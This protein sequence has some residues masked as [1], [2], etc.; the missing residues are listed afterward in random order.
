MDIDRKTGRKQTASHSKK[1]A[2][3]E[4]EE[5]AAVT[6]DSQMTDSSFTS[7]LL[8]FIM[9]SRTLMCLSSKMRQSCPLSLAK[10]TQV[11]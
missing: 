11:L 4:E 7:D 6:D 2:E 3:G 9:C 10:P 8:G 5:L 1:Q